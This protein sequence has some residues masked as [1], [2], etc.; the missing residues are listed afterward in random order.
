MTAAKT[1]LM[2][3]SPK[4][5]RDE[6]FREPLAVFEKSGAAVTVVSTVKGRAEGML[7]DSYDI[8]TTVDEVAERLYDAM[9]IVGGR[10]SAEHLWD[11]PTIHT[12]LQ[13]HQAAGKVISGICLSAATLAKAGTLTGHKATVFG[14]EDAVEALKAG[15]ADYQVAP[16]VTDGKIVT[17]EGPKVATDFA[18]AILAALG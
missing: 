7:G 1:I 16:V 12:M 13:R 11:H 4:M 6:E 18:K 2:V 8:E 3:I 14:R 10:G 9:V 17:G 5:Y 15:G